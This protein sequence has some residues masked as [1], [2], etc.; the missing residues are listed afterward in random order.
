MS[1]PASNN[2]AVRES[3]DTTV[4]A[5]ASAQKRSVM[6][7]MLR[8]ATSCVPAAADEDSRASIEVYA[9]QRDSQPRAD[10]ASGS[11]TSVVLAASAASAASATHDRSVAHRPP[12][13]EPDLSQLVP[14][15]RSADDLEA[16]QVKFKKVLGTARTFLSNQMEKLKDDPYDITLKVITGGKMVASLL[17]VPFLGPLFGIIENIVTNLQTVQLRQ[18]GV[19]EFMDHLIDIVETV[20]PLVNMDKNE[21]CSAIVVKRVQQLTNLLNEV[22]EYLKQLNSKLAAFYGMGRISPNVANNIQGAL[23][24]FQSR[25]DRIN[26]TLGTAIQVDSTMRLVVMSRKIDHVVEGV[27]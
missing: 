1:S 20:T 25:L 16:K 22:D 24:V 11:S 8:L 14:I 9:E 12:P 13:N 4:Q 21:S 27:D 19:S 17:P 3:V 6:S 15:K 5:P 10:P 2:P 26:E 18:N 23:D 7:S